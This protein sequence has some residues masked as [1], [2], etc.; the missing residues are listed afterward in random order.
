M[1]LVAQSGGAPAFPAKPIRLIVSSPPGNPPD[2]VSRIVAEPLAATLGK[3][4]LVENRAGGNGTIGMAA[5]A[6]AV[7]DGHTLGYIGV[8]QMVAPSLMSEMPYDTVRDLAPV[9]QLTWTATILIV[10]PSS[11]LQTVSD[12]VAAAKAKPGALMYASAGN[13]TP[14]HLAS[15]LFKNRAGIDVQHV[16][17]KGMTEGLTAVLGAQVDIAFAGA[18][19]ALPLIKA[20]KLRALG[21]A[22]ARRLPAS[23]EL[24]TIAELGF[25]GYQLNEWHGVVAPARTPPAVIAKLAA[26]LSRIVALPEIQARLAHLALYPAEKLGPEALAAI[27]QTEVPRWKQIVR[28]VGIRAE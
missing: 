11:P 24:P 17:Y 7:P 20:G 19:T 23:P 6:K 14:S 18:A 22:G 21:T 15:E 26:E 1:P 28:D 10:R 13:A 27:I 16:P 9:T 25:A 4:V 12:F 5:V 2:A 3:P 8:P